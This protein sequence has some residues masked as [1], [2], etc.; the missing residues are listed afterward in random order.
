QEKPTAIQIITDNNKSPTKTTEEG[1]GNTDK[2]TSQKVETVQ[3]TN[4]TTNKITATPIT[5]NNI[6]KTAT[7]NKKSIANQNSQKAETNKKTDSDKQT[8]INTNNPENQKA[9][10]TEKKPVNQQHQASKN[11]QP[12]N[13]NL[14]KQAKDKQQPPNQPPTNQPP[15]SATAKKSRGLVG[16][17]LLLGITG[18]GIGV[19][20]LTE[21]RTLQANGQNTAIT[22]KL[23]TLNKKITQLNENT[24]NTLKKQLERLV[25]Q[26]TSSKTAETRF[27][28]R[29]ASLEQ[30]QTG[31]RNSIKM[32]INKALNSN[33]EAADSLL[34]KVNAIELSQKG[35]AKNLSQIMTAGNEANAK[36]ITQQEVSYLL[37]MANYKL[38]SENDVVGA[39]S[40]L[41][42]AENKLL[43]ANQGQTDDMIDAIREKNIQL[44]GVKQIDIN[45]LVSQLKAIMRQ[46]PNLTIKT[47]K[48]SD[49]TDVNTTNAKASTNALGKIGAIIASGIKFTPMNPNQIDISV[50]TLL[51]EKRLMQADLKTAELAIQS[52]NKILLTESIRS[53]T[54]S[55]SKYFANDNTAQ[56]IKQKLTTITQS[57]L[58][59]V[60][61]DL[62][63]LV[64]QFKQNQKTAQ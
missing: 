59:T 21:L 47:E 19:Y 36:G 3:K 10:L 43:V 29:I 30:M 40:L 18:T 55:L 7:N 24:N 20:T 57:E 62:S 6:T 9:I 51:I 22:A 17:A 11:Q 41:K 5:E 28:E 32:T 38:Q 13:A 16:L 49:T 35:L 50:E 45:G 54:D 56:S 46:V 60:L 26:Q 63:D 33:M 64:S 27:N 12:N 48:I 53:I 42:I 2:T 8:T 37:R 25:N 44:S 15:T 14:S 52:H 23:A 58:E 34:S 4:S 31:L 61:P 1:G 39:S